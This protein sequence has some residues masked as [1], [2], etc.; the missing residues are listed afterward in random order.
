MYLIEAPVKQCHIDKQSHSPMSCPVA[1]A[2]IEA[3]GCTVV[4][5]LSMT[6]LYPRDLVAG[7]KRHEAIRLRPSAETKV[8]I[9]SYD[10]NQVM[11]PFVARY[12]IVNY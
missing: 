5:E 11:T 9:A 2:L 10:N 6:M 4:V 3:T 7:T 8:I 1:L 12:M